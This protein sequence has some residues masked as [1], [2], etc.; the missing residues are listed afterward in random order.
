MNSDLSPDEERIAKWQ[1]PLCDKLA[2]KDDLV[3]SYGSTIVT[4]AC[5]YAI[6]EKLQVAMDF[7]RNVTDKNP[8]QYF[9]SRVVIRWIRDR[10][11]EGQAYWSSDSTG[12]GHWLDLSWDYLSKADEPYKICAHELVH[13]FYRTSPLHTRGK[14]WGGNEGWGEGFCDFL[15]GPVMNH[16]GLDGKQWWWKVIDAGEKNKPGTHQNPAGQFVKMAQQKHWGASKR[17]EF[18]DWFID[19]IDA[20]RQFLN[21]LFEDFADRPLSQV[22][23]PTTEME[24]KYR[25]K[26]ML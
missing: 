13:P 9:G 18:I 6:A 16:I 22:L 3:F 26:G 21:S 15:R 1:S 25:N 7:L 11:K 14:P 2:K 19:D 17:D 24:R 12:K 20:L 10:E 23:I 4:M 8:T 5:A